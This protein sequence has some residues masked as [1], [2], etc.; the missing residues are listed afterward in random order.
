MILNIGCGNAKIQDD[1]YEAGYHN[2]VNN[3]ISKICIDEM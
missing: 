2:I 1:L 3:D